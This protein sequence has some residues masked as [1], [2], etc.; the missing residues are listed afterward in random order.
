MDTIQAAILLAKFNEFKSNEIKNRRK[1]VSCYIKNL[2]ILEE[3][4]FI[5]LPIFDETNKSVYA[6]FSILINNRDRFLEFLKIN[7]I[8]FAIHYPV[9]LHLQPAFSY[10]GYK[11]GDFPVSEELS[12]KI[13]SIPLDAYKTND[14]INN[15]CDIIKRFFKS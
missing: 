7:L 6:Q 4:G 2:K 15:V 5:K 10:L 3:N 12:K 13:V 11:K 9:P 8:P 1:V 14:E